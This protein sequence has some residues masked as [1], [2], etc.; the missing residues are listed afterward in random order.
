MSARTNK[1]LNLLTNNRISD[2]HID[3]RHEDLH[4]KN[5]GLGYSDLEHD[6]GQLKLLHEDFTEVFDGD[7]LVSYQ[8]LEELI[9]IERD[10]Q[11]LKNIGTSFHELVEVQ[12][13]D[14]DEIGNTVEHVEVV[15]EKGV[16]E[17]EKASGLAELLRSRTVRTMGGA[18]VGGLLFGGVG[19]I[20]GGYI[21]ILFGSGV[22]TGGGAI[23]GALSA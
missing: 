10:I 22:G 20:L 19:S 5:N 15:V 7:A 12:G 1:K 23:V 17:L 13:E 18:V 21:G 8:Q 3:I 14:L 2:D 6:I 16:A 9:K 11:D 4:E